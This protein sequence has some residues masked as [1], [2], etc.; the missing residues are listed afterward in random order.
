MKHDLGTEPPNIVSAEV[1]VM[2]THVNR[3]TSIQSEDPAIKGG[4][5]PSNPADHGARDRKMRDGGCGDGLRSASAEG[6]ERVAWAG[7]N[8]H[9]GF[10]GRSDDREQGKKG[11][12]RGVRGN[13]ND[14]SRKFEGTFAARNAPRRHQFGSNHVRVSVPE[15]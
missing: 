9:A 14:F 3:L 13:E 5:I 2:A 6:A 7:Q 12:S 1:E 11:L 4:I 15:L 8:E 10:F